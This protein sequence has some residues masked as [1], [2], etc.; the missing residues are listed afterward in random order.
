[1]TILHPIETLTQGQANDLITHNQSDA[2]L[3]I[4]LRLNA[5]PDAN[6]MVVCLTKIT[7]AKHMQEDLFE[8][9]AELLG[10][11]SNLIERCEGGDADMIALARELHASTTELL[12]ADR[13]MLEEMAR[14]CVERGD[15]PMRPE[16][17]RIEFTAHRA[18][19]IGE[20]TGNDTETETETS[21]DQTRRDVGE[22]GH[23]DMEEEEAEID[24]PTR[25]TDDM[26]QPHLSRGLAIAD[27]TT[28]QITPM[29]TSDPVPEDVIDPGI[30]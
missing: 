14:E 15:E 4:L 22:G 9:R 3:E 25:L 13:T 7:I 26:P 16:H 23:A 1:M 27:P 30:E 18:L 11:A 29:P 12:A 28:G 17:H 6:K 19:P 24:L 2:G 8:T 10:E 5:E 20:G 21:T